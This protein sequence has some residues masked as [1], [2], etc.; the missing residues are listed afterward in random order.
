MI[1]EE[2]RAVIVAAGLTPDQTQLDQ[3]LK[4]IAKVKGIQRFTANGT[5]VVPDRNFDDLCFWVRRW[6]RRW[7]NLTNHGGLSKLLWRKRRWCRPIDTSST[8]RRCFWSVDLHHHWCRRLRW[9]NRGGWW[10]WRQY[11]RRLIGNPYWRWRGPNRRC[12]SQHLSGPRWWFWI[13]AWWL[14]E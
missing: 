2:L 3:L 10:Q 11:D 14:F 4:S 8:L 9:C 7:R 1:A 12:T 5:F 13:S 6:W